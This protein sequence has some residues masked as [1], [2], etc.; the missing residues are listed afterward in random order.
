MA[1]KK[2]HRLS[3]ADA[4]KYGKLGGSPIL[5]AFAEHRVIKGYK[6]THSVGNWD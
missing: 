2:A 6:V 5:K 3:H 1:K 4:V